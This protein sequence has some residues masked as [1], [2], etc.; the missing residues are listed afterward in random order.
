MLMNQ[1]DR[2]QK[3]TPPFTVAIIGGGFT[4]AMLAAQL[5]R[6][7]GGSVSVLLIEKGERLGRGVAYSTEC[8]RSGSLH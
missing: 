6:N 8:R 7:S 2:D 1:K 3:K 5:L 4:G